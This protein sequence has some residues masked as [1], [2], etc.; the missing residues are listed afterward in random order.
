LGR[1]ALSRNTMPSSTPGSTPAGRATRSDNQN[2]P[3]DD[4]E[5]EVVTEVADETGAIGVVAEQ[6]SVFLQRERVD[7]TRV[8]GAG[9]ELCGDVD[10][11]YFMR[12]RDIQS[13]AAL[14]EEF[15]DPWLKLLRREVVETISHGLAGFAGKQSVN[16]GGPAVGYR[17]SHHSI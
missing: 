3:A 12:Q 2:P 8:S 5:P 13:A 4:D 6:C 16:E 11:G 7:C 15:T 9:S 14:G 10:G 1:P 17:M